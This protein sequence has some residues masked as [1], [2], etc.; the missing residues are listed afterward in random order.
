MMMPHIDPA[1][2]GSGGAPLPQDAHGAKRGRVIDPEN[3]YSNG[4]IPTVSGP[5]R[6][7]FYSRGVV[8]SRKVLR[9][10][11]GK[12]DGYASDTGD[13]A[14]ASSNKE[15]FKRRNSIAGGV[16][17]SDLAVLSLIEEHKARANDVGSTIPANP[18]I[19]KREP[20]K[21][22][23]F[24][25][26]GLA[27]D[28]PMSA[29]AAVEDYEGEMLLP[30][31]PLIV[32]QVTNIAP[33]GLSQRRRDVISGSN[34]DALG[35]DASATPHDILG[36]A[37][38]SLAANGG[39]ASLGDA[40]QYANID[41]SLGPSAS[42]M[43]M[44]PPLS[45]TSFKPSSDS[46]LE[47][48]FDIGGAGMPSQQSQQLTSQHYSHHPYHQQT[49]P[50]PYGYSQ[51]G[52]Q[53]AGWPYATA[54][55]HSPQQAARGASA[56]AYP[57]YAQQL[58]YSHYRYASTNLP[59][60]SPGSYAASTP[61]EAGNYYPLPAHGEGSLSQLADMSL[62]R[63]GNLS[64]SQEN[65]NDGQG[66]RSSSVSSLNGSQGPGAGTRGEG[67]ALPLPPSQA[68]ADKG[69]PREPL[70]EYGTSQSQSQGQG[71]GD[72]SEGAQAAGLAVGDVAA[73]AIAAAAAQNSQEANGEEM[74]E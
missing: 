69:L 26:D 30:V 1:L 72:A 59:T 40:Q 73:A 31:S 70:I 47:P 25:R 55:D 3:T 65:D 68:E 33:R 11:R 37:V 60:G 18:F 52:A 63:F 27:P 16:S 7:S 57:S 42:Q 5:F 54:S 39:I 50:H 23:S 44:M 61:Q 48:W 49:T 20:G 22:P 71:R 53:T 51:V 32:A 19:V 35:L 58:P 45:Q 46:Q 67:E 62:A 56:S 12:A 9:A 34:I 6:P 14:T 41:P 21:L 29:P 2:G 43:G 66:R 28:T 74:E 8:P 36:Y 15:K 17:L 13:I 10:A 38:P 24:A 4:A 64:Q